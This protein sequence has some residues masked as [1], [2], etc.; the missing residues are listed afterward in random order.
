M[1]NFAIPTYMAALRL[2]HQEISLAQA[3]L[4]A[5]QD[6]AVEDRHKDRIRQSMDFIIK[7]AVKYGLETV[8]TRAERL[9]IAALPDEILG[10]GEIQ[11]QCLALLEAFEDDT[12]FLY[13]YAYPKDKGL[14]FT[15]C[16][17]DWA[18]TLS[19]FPSAKNDIEAAVDC[20]ALGHNTACA[21]HLMRVLE[22]GLRALAANVDRTFDKQQ[23]HNIIEEIESAI[24]EDR[25]K[26]PRGE[27][28]DDRLTFL[29]A[30]AKEFFYFKDGW[31]NHTAHNRVSYDESM[32]KGLI[33]HVRSFMNH[34]ST[35][36]SENPQV[37][38]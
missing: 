5:R 7:K 8:A 29:S 1:F 31:R 26:L 33:D 10:W 34:L 37:S 20:F 30:A 16:A 22:Y 19:A 9:S 32:A 21:Y 36:L 38:T 3:N 4:H 11:R 13:L 14:I 24:E 6:Q 27:L 2:V 17:G 25:K 28:K 18:A 12:K 35:K 23:W 15:R